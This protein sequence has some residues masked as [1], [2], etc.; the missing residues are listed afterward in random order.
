[1]VSWYATAH[2]ARMLRKLFAILQLSALSSLISAV[3][4]FV[5][6]KAHASLTDGLVG[7]WTFNGPDLN[8]FTGTALDRSGQGNNG[9]LIAFSTTTSTVIGKLGQAL[10]FNGATTY[11]DAGRTSSENIT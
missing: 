5:P 9:N 7:Y 8:W 4:F 3:V 6:Q 10:S 11:V 1:M 2:A